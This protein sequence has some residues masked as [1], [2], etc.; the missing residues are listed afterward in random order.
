[1]TAVDQVVGEQPWRRLDPRMLVVG[2]LGSLGRLV[3]LV[4]ILL[5]T[6]G[7]GDPVRLWIAAVAAGVVVLAGIVRWRTTRYRITADRVEL[8]TGWLRRQRRSVPRDRIRSVDLT[9]R[10]LHRAFGLSVVQVGAA[11]GS[12]LESAGLSLDAV[13]RAEADLLRRELLDRSGPAAVAAQEAAPGELLARLDWS[14]LRFAPLTFSS[15]AG[16]GAIGATLFNLVDDLGVDPR[17]IGAVDDAAGRFASAPIWLGVLVVVGVLLVLAVVG[18][19]LLYAERW[20]GYRL[21]READGTLRVKRGLL[22][23]RSLSVAEQRLRGAEISEPV[24]LRFGRGAQCRALSTGLSRDAQGGAL[25]PPAPRAEA[26]RVASATLRAH[27]AEITGAALRTHPAAARTRRL[28]RTLVPAVVVCAAAFLL[29]PGWA[30]PTSLLLLPV[31]VLLGLDR[32]AQLGHQLT[33]RYLV[34]RQGSLVRTTVAL[35]RD[36]VIGWTVRQSVFQRRAG[37]VTVEAVTA[38]GQGGYTVLDVAAAD[39]V[40]LADAAVPGLITPFLRR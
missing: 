8:H 32:Y 27:P 29:G 10:L 34:A 15:I 20:Y 4:L 22:T 14:W 23:Q 1:M 3:P 17:D 18:S 12:P 33:A 7:T 38:A 25:Q 6:G 13:S 28:T 11:S 9:A 26:H 37:V 16:I 21:T 2:P 40:A 24:L 31:A 39:G 19:V 5:V 36:G 35:Q 30:G